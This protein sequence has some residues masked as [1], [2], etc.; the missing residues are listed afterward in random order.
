MSKRCFMFEGQGSQFQGMGRDIYDGF[1]PARRVFKTGSEVLGISL[2]ELCFDT[3][4]ERLDLTQNSQI[5]VFTVSM[6]IYNILS[7]KGFKPDYYAGFSLGEY[8]ALCASG[9]VSLEDGFTIVKKRGEL[10]QKCAEEKRGAMYAIIGLEDNVIEEVCAKTEGYVAPVNYNCPGQLVIAGDEESAAIA[11]QECMENGALK[12]VRLAVNG[13]FH[14]KHME[15]AA[16]EF[17]EFLRGF[18]FNL[19][20]GIFFSNVYGG[21]FIGTNIPEYLARHMTSP[22]LWKNEI[23]CLVAAGCTE[24]YEIGCKKTLS[25]FNRKIDRTL[26]TTSLSSADSIAFLDLADV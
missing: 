2:E 23:A 10:M 25:G 17:Y 6:A 5:A 4:E 14:S 22:V 3:G 21:A 16:K 11:A 24:F 26:S 19:P 8:S 12:A 20:D 18:A 15:D 7:E 13:A 9:V 1:E